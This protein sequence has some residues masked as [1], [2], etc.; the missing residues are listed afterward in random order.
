MVL[1]YSQTKS[2]AYSHI[3]ERRFKV[4][5]LERKIEI[6]EEEED[7]GEIGKGNNLMSFKI[8]FYQN[9]ITCNAHVAFSIHC[10][11]RTLT[12]GLIWTIIKV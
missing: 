8:F 4:W 10:I 3:Y 2:T 1:Y 9:F 11:N 5:I 6:E 7:K 12:E